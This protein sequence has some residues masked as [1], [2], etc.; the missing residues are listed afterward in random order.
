V[1][2]I[3]PARPDEIEIIQADLSKDKRWEQVDLTKG[4]VFVATKDGEIVQYIQSRLVWQ[5]EPLKWMRGKKKTLNAHEQK[6]ST[7][8]LIF[9]ME[10]WL[11]DPHH[12]PFVRFYFCTIKNKVMQKL[13]QS[14]GMLP[15]Y[16]GCRFFGK[17]L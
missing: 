9:A 17:D 4:I 12:N 11:R 5:V 10:R 8:R 3:R 1:I 13:A 14:F 6:K 15:L 16:N 2:E 7:Y